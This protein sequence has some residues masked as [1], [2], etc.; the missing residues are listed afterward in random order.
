MES[1]EDVEEVSR[2]DI[3]DTLG[4]YILALLFSEIVTDLF[5]D[6]SSSLSSLSSSS[7]N[8]NNA[9]ILAVMKTIKDS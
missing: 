9:T 2:N 7:S 3:L 8:D 1:E 5:E 6:T 4:T